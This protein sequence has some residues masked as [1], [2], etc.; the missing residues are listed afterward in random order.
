[1]GARISG[2]GS[3]I[4]VTA[5]MKR[6]VLPHRR[7]PHIVAAIGDSRVAALYLDST[8]RNK[9][10]H[11]PLGWANALLGQR[12]IYGDSLGV[13]GNRTDQMLARLSTA[14]A[15]GA[16]TLYIQ[17]GVNDIAQN[18]PTAGTS[19]ATAFANIK[20][21]AEAARAAGMTVVIEA[22]VGGNTMN[23]AALVGQVNDLNARLYEYAER[24][25]GVHL[26]DARPVVLQPTFSD[27]ALQFK[28]GH[29]YDGTHVSGRGGLYWGES[30]A[31]LL[32]PVIPARMMTL[33]RNRAELPGNGR[34]HLALNPLFATA[35]GGVLVNGATGTVPGNWNGYRSNTSSTVAFS[36]QADASGF[37][38]NAIVDF[39]AVAQGDQARLFQDIGTSNWQAGDVVEAYAEVQVTG[40]PAILGALW[41]Q[42]TNNTGS[43]G[44][45]YDNMDMIA[46]TTTNFNG[47]DKAIASLT[48]KTRPF[49]ILPTVGAGQYLQLSVRAQATGAGSCQF[50]VKQCGVRRR[51]AGY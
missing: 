34:R 10:A 1:M 41:L 42:L 50:I 3:N 14:I 12:M 2:N 30:L 5:L 47:P 24:T 16:G 9:C 21:M 7:L 19:G 8:Q 31:A 4:A 36:T 23:T 37:G 11:S 17:G 6:S 13:S 25:P 51:D 20:T 28:T 43:G 32:G 35:T 48:L 33:G 40:T 18:Y 22:E 38:N 45:S 39:T 15:T 27:T 46:T 29:S 44:A 49:T 26:H